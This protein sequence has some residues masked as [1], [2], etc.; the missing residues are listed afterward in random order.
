MFD[1]KE[2]I[3]IINTIIVVYVIIFKLKLKRLLFKDCVLS[4]FN[5]FLFLI[6]CLFWFYRMKIFFCVIVY[7]RKLFSL[8]TKILIFII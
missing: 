4:L 1:F 5:L 7:N 2:I 8:K 3:I 6:L